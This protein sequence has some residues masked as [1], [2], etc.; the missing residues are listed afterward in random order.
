MQEVVITSGASNDA[1]RHRAAQAFKR[2]LQQGQNKQSFLSK[3][4]ALRCLPDKGIQIAT[5]RSIEHHIRLKRLQSAQF[6]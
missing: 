1:C 5:P 2:T 3:H 4:T 6:C